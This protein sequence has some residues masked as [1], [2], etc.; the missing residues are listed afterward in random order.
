MHKL[1]KRKETGIALYLHLKISNDWLSESDHKEGKKH[2]IKLNNIEKKNI[3]EKKAED[4]M[5]FKLH[6]TK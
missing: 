5:I 2:Q 3:R 1:S 4:K 6:R